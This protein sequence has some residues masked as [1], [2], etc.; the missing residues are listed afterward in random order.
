MVNDRSIMAEE[1][2]CAME[3]LGGGA[4]ASSQFVGGHGVVSIF[5]IKALLSG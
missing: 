1:L 5:V 3:V 2:S 4:M